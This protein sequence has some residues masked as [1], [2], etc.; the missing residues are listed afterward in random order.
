MARRK[1]PYLPTVNSSSLKSSDALAAFGMSLSVYVLAGPFLAGLD[2]PGLV[3]TQLLAFAL[4]ALLMAATRPDGWQAIGWRPCK[5]MTLVGAA[6]IACSLWYW[7]AHWITPIGSDWASAEQSEQWSQVLAL[8][9]RPL[10]E[11]LLLFALL[12]ALCEE[13]LHRGV[14]APSL[15]RRIGFWPGLLLSSLLFGLFHLNLARLLPTTL[16]GMAAGFVRLRSGS[17]WPAVLL[18]FL[19]NASLL[20]AAVGGLWLSGPIALASVVVTTLGV[21]LTHNSLNLQDNDEGNEKYT[22]VNN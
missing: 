21:Y 2:T 18:H 20:T 6:V 19:Y 9:S 1:V 7:N 3:L 5:A 8:P 14:I 16:L 11:S 22:I 4:P 15:A 12:P 17:L 13:L 10:I